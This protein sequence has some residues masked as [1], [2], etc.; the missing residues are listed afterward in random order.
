[1][2]VLPTRSSPPTWTSF[3]PISASEDRAS[4]KRAFDNNEKNERGD[5]YEA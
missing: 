3:T 4:H 5:H 1:L 2:T